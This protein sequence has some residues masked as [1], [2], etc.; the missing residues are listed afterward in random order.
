M[1]VHGK[2]D[3]VGL[4]PQAQSTQLDRVSGGSRWSYARSC[5]SH[6]RMLVASTLAGKIS[7]TPRCARQ[8]VTIAPAAHP[9]GHRDHRRQLIFT[10]NGVRLHEPTSPLQ[11]VFG[12]LRQGIR[13]L[14]RATGSIKCHQQCAD[15]SRRGHPLLWFHCRCLCN[16]DFGLRSTSAVGHR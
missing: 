13:L 9:G 15:I 10:C 5:K 3:G 2:F 4:A 12:S 6:A 1:K 16:V 7:L 8:K 11:L 14:V